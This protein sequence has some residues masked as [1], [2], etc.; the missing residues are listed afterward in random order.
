V[1]FPLRAV[2]G[3]EKST[4]ELTYGA[5][6]DSARPTRY[7]LVL[8]AEPGCEIR[9]I[10]ALRGFLKLSLRRFKL[11]CVEARELGGGAP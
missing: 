7:A 11:R 6:P 10:H 2:P 4:A 8:A 1:S 5:G 9:S 3:F